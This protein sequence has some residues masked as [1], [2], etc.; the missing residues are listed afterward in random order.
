MRKSWPDTDSL[1]T[2][3]MDGGRQHAGDALA[4][5]IETMLLPRLLAEHALTRSLTGAIQPD[6]AELA[7]RIA[8]SAASDDIDSLSELIR[9]SFQRAEDTER[10]LLRLMAPAARLLGGWGEEGKLPFPTVDRAVRALQQLV[11]MFEN[12]RRPNASRGWRAGSILLAA[13]PG[14][15]HT[16]GLKVVEELFRRDGWSLTMLP[17]PSRA[18]IIQVVERD[19]IHVVGFSAGAPDAGDAIRALARDI[20]AASLNPAIRLVVG[21]P[22]VSVGALSAEE[23]QVDAAPLD[24]PAAIEA[25]RGFLS[26]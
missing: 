8:E 2:A 18:Q 4:N 22:A 24:G 1:A 7:V 20:R 23:L 12:D 17:S 6:E 26:G 11:D 14:D 16:F 13:L 5:R 15:Q 21:G 3:S 25:I 10:V 19:F 9:N